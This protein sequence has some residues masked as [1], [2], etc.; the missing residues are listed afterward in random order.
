[1][2]T[3]VAQK[4]L[5]QL[6]VHLPRLE[7]PHLTVTVL[8]KRT[9]NSSKRCVK[10]NTKMVKKYYVLRLIWPTPTCICVTLCCT[11]SSMLITT[12][13]ATNG[14]FTQCMILPMDNPIP[15]KKS[16]IPSVPW[17]L[18]HTVHYTIG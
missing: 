15:S 6:K 10:E 4:K 17:S 11:A 7:N 8:S 16:R 2:W 5:L 18:F 9:Y 1:M 3:T 13:Q 14:A 12:V